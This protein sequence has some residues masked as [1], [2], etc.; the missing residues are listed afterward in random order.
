MPLSRTLV[1]LLLVTGCDQFLNS[2]PQ[3]ERIGKLE[4][5]VAVLEAALTE[6]KDEKAGQEREMSRC[7]DEAGETYWKYVQLNG[8]GKPQ[9]NGDVKWT[10]SV[11]VFDQASKLKQNAIEE[12]RVRYGK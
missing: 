9:A 10:A 11:P 6:K 3:N 12:C 8:R 7:L 5:R 1:V 2:A 4:A